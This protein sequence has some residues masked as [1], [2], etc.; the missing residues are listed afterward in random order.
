M[1]TRREA[2]IRAFAAIAESFAHLFVGEGISSPEIEKLLRSV[3]VH[4][5]AKGE[6][7]KGSP[8]SDSRVALLTGVDRHV[9]ASILKGPPRANPGLET[10]RHRLNRVLAEWHS[11]PD[12]LEGGRPKDLEIRGGR[13]RRTFWTLVRSHAKDVW[14]GLMLDELLKVAAVEKLADGRVRPLMRSYKAS[15]LSEAGLDELAYRVRDLTQTLLYNLSH[16][17]MPRVCGTVQSIDVD[18]Q[19]LPLVRRELLARSDVTLNALDQLLNN[20]KLRRTGRSRARRVRIGWACYS[21]E[22]AL[23]EELRNEEKQ[24][25]EYS[26]Q[27]W[28][29]ARPRQ[30]RPKG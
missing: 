20:Q 5:A 10:R 18:E 2:V 27:R 26:N 1:D 12:Y 9:V 29:A 22:E 14:P 28:K 11:D 24:S 23:P 30:G 19:N 4:T 13:R 15:Q 6:E 3:L 7:A 8:P 25:F 17:D 16:S 21:F